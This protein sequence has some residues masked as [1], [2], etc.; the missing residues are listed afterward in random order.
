M[1]KVSIAGALLDALSSK[2]EV[3]LAKAIRSPK[4][5]ETVASFI[6]RRLS[7]LSAI[8]IGYISKLAE[9]LVSAA[10]YLNELSPGE[11]IDIEKIPI[12][13][14]L[15]GDETAGKRLF[16]SGEWNIPGTD[17]WFQ[18]SGTLPDVTGFDDIAE[19]AYGLAS[20]YIERYPQKFEYPKGA[21]E[22]Q[23]NIRFTA[24]ERGF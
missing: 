10:D 23:I 11:Q 21:D 4:P 20:G 6:E 7:G 16:W 5:T 22:T 15:F 17:E 13:G 1:A 14:N 12:N 3:G 19:Q 18:F 24:I 9:S 8:D 2:A